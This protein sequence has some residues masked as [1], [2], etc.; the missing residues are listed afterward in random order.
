[1]L[2]TSGSPS[3]SYSVDF[4]YFYRSVSSFVHRSGFL[5][6]QFASDFG[7][8][9]LTTVKESD[10]GVGVVLFPP[11]ELPVGGIAKDDGTLAT[12]IGSLLEDHFEFFDNPPIL[13]LSSCI[14][15][16]A[17]AA[18]VLTGES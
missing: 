6:R 14:G 8:S 7:G 18:V 12:G 11:R 15:A 4:K 13:S 3:A 2:S 1:M 10:T 16:S 5:I 17:T 9:I